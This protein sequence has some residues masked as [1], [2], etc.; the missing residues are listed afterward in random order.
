M[1]ITA[2]RDVLMEGQGQKLQLSLNKLVYSLMPPHR[3]TLY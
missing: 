2:R 1:Y 3:D